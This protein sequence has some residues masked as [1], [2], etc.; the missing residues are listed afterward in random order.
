MSILFTVGTVKRRVIPLFHIA[1]TGDYSSNIINP[2]EIFTVST[3][4]KLY[5]R[6]DFWYNIVTLEIIKKISRIL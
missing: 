6:E 4:K 5:F 2:K 1:G 3:Q